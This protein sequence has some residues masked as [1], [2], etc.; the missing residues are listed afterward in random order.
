MPIEA[1]PPAAPATLAIV[2]GGGDLPMRLIDACRA[3][4][5]PVF[6]LALE[7]QARAG[8]FADVP[9]AWI[10]M[11]EAGTAIDL[12]RGAG[13]GEIV[14][15]GRVRR[16]SL[17][18]LRPDRRALAFLAKVGLRI[19]GD[20]SVLSLVVRELEGEGF[21]VVGPDDV[22]GELLASPGVY[23]AHTPDGEAWRD[24]RRGADVARALG[25]VDVGQAVVV[26]QAIVLAVEAVEGTDSMLER[27]AGLRREGPPGVL[28]KL[29]KPGQERRV[30]LPTIGLATVLRASAAGLRGIAIEAGA[31]LVIDRAA[32]VEAADK[33][34]LFVVAFTPGDLTPDC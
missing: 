32:I 3:V 21:R 11:G 30:D 29:S 13:A 14:F 33:A 1:E 24:I 23:G 10:R 22:L 16:P 5:R 28:V 4:D 6:V 8:A 25:S 15:A 31:S 19:L 17:A 9:H 34:G 20:D 26:Q 7:G 2:A 27:A 18:A 12:L